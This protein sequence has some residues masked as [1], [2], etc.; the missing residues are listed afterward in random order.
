[1]ELER[2]QKSA[3]SSGLTS[4]QSHLRILTRVQIDHRGLICETCR[5]LTGGTRGRDV[6]TQGGPPDWSLAEHKA[7]R[8][9][10][11]LQAFS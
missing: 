5:H 3:A 8:P 6:T 2:K 11:H 7:Q 9:P 10:N 1:M 4:P